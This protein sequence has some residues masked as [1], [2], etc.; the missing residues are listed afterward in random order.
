MKSINLKIV[1]SGMV[2]MVGFR[3]YAKQQADFLHIKGYVRNT[4]R[5][6]VEIFAQGPGD[7]MPQFEDMIRQGPSRS[8]V[9]RFLREEVNTD[10]VYEKFSIRM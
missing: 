6:E 9:E 2:Q 4:V 7:V 5:G 3:W 1:V 8:R 10:K